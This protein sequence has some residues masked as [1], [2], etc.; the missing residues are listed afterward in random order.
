M[1]RHHR[2]RSTALK[3]GGSSG[4][5]ERWLVSYA[6]FITLLFAFFTTMYAISTVDARKLAPMAASLQKA[7]DSRPGD[8]V[9]ASG[10]PA[11]AG[12]DSARP[13]VADPVVIMA[14]GKRLSEVRAQLAKE[15]ADAVASGRLELS[16]DPRGLVLSLPEGATFD[17]GRAEVSASARDLIARLA[18]TLR[19]LGNA[20]RIEGHTDDIP[21]HTARY[22]SN[23]ELSTARASA[24]VAFVIETHGFGPERLSAAGYGEFHPR[25]AND[26]A[27]NR[28]RNRRVDIVVLNPAS[29]E[30]EPQHHADTRPAQVAPRSPRGGLEPGESN[31]EGGR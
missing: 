25:V 29:A 26:S 17:V 3:A 5:H 2:R 18:A 10:G 8:G 12:M 13:R 6:D 7:F 27:E 16:E 22:G 20:I 11:G 19:P 28:A 30:Q 14:T 24:V 4:S 15:L 23:W 9:L 1:K 31:R 21:I